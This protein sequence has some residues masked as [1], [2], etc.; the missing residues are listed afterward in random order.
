MGL[1]TKN[2]PPE[3]ARSRPAGPAPREDWPVLHYGPIREFDGSTGT[4][5]SPASSTT[6]SR[7][8]RGAAGPAER[9][10]RCR[11]ALRDR[12]DHARQHV[13]RRV[14][15]HDH[16][17]GE[18]RSAE[19]KWVIAALRARLHLEPLARGDGRRRRAARLAQPRRG[20]RRPTTGGR[21][22]SWSPSGT[23]G[24]ARSGSR[25]WSSARRTTRG[26]WEVRGYH[27]HAEPFA[28]ERYSY[29]EGRE[30]R[31]RALGPSPASVRREPGARSAICAR[32]TRRR[33]ASR[34]RRPSRPPRAAR[35]RA[36]PRR[37]CARPRCSR[38]DRGVRPGGTP[39]RS[40]GRGR[41]AR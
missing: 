20:P 37:R 15:P 7:S 21:C 18:A 22:G 17:A 23:R 9:H 33:P 24:R 5:R 28:E 13:G 4:S 16:R 3:I 40:R 12:L 11:H 8:L 32:A 25:A 38:G 29:Q 1:F 34:A 6:R 30:G 41:R 26:F 39:S 35:T 19:A 10:G 27:I 36:S 31:A 2:Y 14:L